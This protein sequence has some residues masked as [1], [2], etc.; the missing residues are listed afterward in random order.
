MS[1]PEPPP[2]TIVDPGRSAVP[3]DVLVSGPSPSAPRRMPARPIL[4]ALAVVGLLAAAVVAAQRSSERPAQ[5]PVPST[6]EVTATVQLVG[7]PLA[8]D[9]FVRLAVLVDIDAGAG[10]VRLLGLTGRG[11]TVE[12]VD[13]E[14]PLLAP[15]EATG[16]AF[17]V[18]VLVNDCGVEPSAPRRLD[19]AV[20]RRDSP[21]AALAATSNPD[22]VRALDRLVAVTCGRPRG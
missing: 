6:Q 3:D 21:A 5:Q 16:L 20:Q 1:S 15:P 4:A 9:P 19:L 8:S 12:P 13:V 17:D 2:V 18:E 22:V 7:R 14:L 11:F 10:P